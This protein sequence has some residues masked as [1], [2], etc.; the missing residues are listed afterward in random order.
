M[1]NKEKSMLRRAAINFNRKLS[2]LG[3]EVNISEIDPDE[4]VARLSAPGATKQQFN[5]RLKQLQSFL[6]S[7]AEDIVKTSSGVNLTKWE[8]KT[9]RQNLDIINKRRERESRKQDTSKWLIENE[10]YRKLK[11]R[12]S[13]SYE[14]FSRYAKSLERQV[15]EQNRY[16]KNIQFKKNYLKALDE[17]I[18]DMELRHLV[19]KLSPAQLV[20]IAKGNRR[21]EIAYYYSERDREDKA[22]VAKEEI[23]NAQQGL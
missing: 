21:L 17:E 18:G 14:D 8:L 6:E 20:R 3:E 10:E 19:E 15:L 9:A 11:L 5:T 12:S 4:E 2:R 23:R 16:Q 13:Q 7:G 1:T 22:E